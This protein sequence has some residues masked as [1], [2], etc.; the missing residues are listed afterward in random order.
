VLRRGSNEKVVGIDLDK[1]IFLSGPYSP[2][3]A[4]MTE[5]VDRMNAARRRFMPVIT[6]AD[7]EDLDTDWL[8]WKV[9]INVD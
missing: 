3:A 7:L 5:I 4:S 1:R 2:S 9:E 6:D 8:D